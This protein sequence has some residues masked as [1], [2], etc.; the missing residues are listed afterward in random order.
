[1]IERDG[2]PAGEILGNGLRQ[3]FE[4]LKRIPVARYQSAGAALDISDSSEAI[5]LRLKNPIRMLEG[6][7]EACYGSDAGEAHA[8]L[9]LAANCGKPA[10]SGRYMGLPAETGRIRRRAKSEINDIFRPF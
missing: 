9:I 7:I 6:R 1:M 4:R 8:T 5:H 3:R 2:R 10:P